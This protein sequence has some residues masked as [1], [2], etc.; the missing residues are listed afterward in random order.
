MKPQKSPPSPQPHPK[1]QHAKSQGA[2]PA[3]PSPKKQHD[4][5]KPKAPK[6]HFFGIH[7]VK[8]LLDYRAMDA[9]ALFVQAGER[10]AQ[11]DDIVAQAQN[12]G[13]S[14]QIIAKD[15]LTEL[16]GSSQHQGVAVL[17]RLPTLADESLLD[18]LV[19]KDDVL[20]LVLDQITD[21]HNLGACL[22]TASAMGADAVIVPK[23]QSATIT[24]T[25]AK[26][27]V[28][29]SEMIP[30]IATNLARCLSEIKSK[31]V[32]VYGTALD[33]TAKPSFAHDLTGKVALVMGSEGDGMRRLTQECCDGLIYIPMTDKDRPQSLNVSVATGMVLYEAMRQRAK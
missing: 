6:P 22:R 8:A 4:D 16:C 31:G 21:A 19:Q 3:K 9:L 28:G 13:L 17:A 1:L 30:V 23:N 27:S 29:A 20:L 2:K 26:V 11:I 15:K 14:V 32:F 25:V 12:L 10:V 33:D 24:P 7:A 18:T 5:K